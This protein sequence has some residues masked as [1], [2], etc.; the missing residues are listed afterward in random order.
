MN[1]RSDVH[2]ASPA[3]IAH[4]AVQSVSAQVSSDTQGHYDDDTTNHTTTNHTATDQPVA[5]YATDELSETDVTNKPGQ[6]PSTTQSAESHSA[7]PKHISSQLADSQS[8]ANIQA[9][10]EARV[11]AQVRAGD[12]AALHALLENYNRRVYSI[13]YRMVGHPEDAAD[14][15]QDALIRILTNLNQFHGRSAF[16]T[17][18]YR[19]AMNIAISHLRK[20]NRTPSHFG[21]NPSTL[22]TQLEDQRE[23]SEK[24]RFFGEPDATSS[25]E[26][27]ERRCTLNAA[28]TTLSEDARALIVLRDMQGLEYQHI[29]S[30]CE[31]PIGTV[32]S[33]L[34]RARVA[35]RK[36]ISGL[37][38][39]KSNTS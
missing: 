10:D 6:Q 19:I 30:I 3:S 20:K 37:E 4:N 21:V 27:S 5:S 16:S 38:N 35:L 25:V 34:F 2:S 12:Q 11:L 18:V 39:Q 14:L 7:N 9:N 26:Q 36:A 15:T 13:I 22:D 17:W 1:A 32:K 33:R 28:F 31:L 23:N 8:V 24:P 29:S